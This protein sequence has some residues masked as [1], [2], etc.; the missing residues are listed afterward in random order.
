MHKNQYLDLILKKLKSDF[1]IDFCVESR[2]K[3]AL[4]F[5]SQAQGTAKSD[6]DID[7][8]LLID[9][10]ALPQ[11]AIERSQLKKKLVREITQKLATSKVDLVL[12]NQASSLLKFQVA[13][14]AVVLYEKSPGD[15]ASFA[16]LALRQHNDDR[17]F[18]QLDKLYLLNKY[19]VK[20]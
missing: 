13:R 20:L 6:S 7:L 8:A 10:E 9:Q 1:L 15:F 11:G 4:L 5:G 16:S 14:N 2:V 3:L 19:N 18:Y 12:L 17:L